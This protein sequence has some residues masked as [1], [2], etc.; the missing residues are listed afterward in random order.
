MAKYWA[1]ACCT[2]SSES[3]PCLNRRSVIKAALL[4]RGILMG[5]LQPQFEGADRAVEGGDLRRYQHLQVVVLRD[6]GEVAG[7]SGL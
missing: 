7:I 4:Q 5:D 1:L 6:A 2:S 3:L